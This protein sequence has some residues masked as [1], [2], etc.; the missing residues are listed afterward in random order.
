[1]KTVLARTILLLFLLAGAAL[2]QN[3]D[4]AFL[5][6]AAGPSSATVSEGMVAGSV[7]FGLQLNYAA[8]LHETGAGQ[9]YLELPL[10]IVADLRGTVDHDVT[11]TISDSLFVTPGLRWRF[12]PQ[13]RVSF[14]AAAGVGIDSFDKSI[15]QVGGGVVSNT[16][17]RITTAAFGFGGGI[18]FRLTRLLSLRAEG[19]DFLTRDGLGGDSGHNHPFFMAG[20]GF[21]F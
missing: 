7:R 14:Y 17:H 13:K 4:L 11:S 21:H 16:N 2:A 9:L 1:M 6:G 3:S 15:S 5:V 12:T 8:Q 19:R 10:M 18:D 20:I